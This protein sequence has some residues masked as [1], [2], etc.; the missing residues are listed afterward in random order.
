M[1][2]LVC[3]SLAVA[4]AWLVALLNRGQSARDFTW[5]Y[6]AAL[7]VRAGV[8][9]YLDLGSVIPAAWENARTTPLF[10]PLPA[11]LIAL[12]F[13]FLPVELAGVVFSMLSAFLLA[14]ALTEDGKYWRLWAFCSAPALVAFGNV[15]WSPL[16]L[17][18]VYLWWLGPIVIC[19]PSLGLA[20]WVARPRFGSLWIGSALVILSLLV[21]PSWPIDW[22][23]NLAKSEHVSP[24]LYAIPGLLALSFWASWHTSSG[25]FY[26][27]WSL[28]PQMAFFYDGLLLWLIPATKRQMWFLCACSWFAFFNMPGVGG[29][30]TFAARLVE[31]WLIYLP[32]L[33]LLLAQVYGGLHYEK[34]VIVG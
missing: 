16:L 6:A 14:W 27:V 17:A 15:Q 9:P 30:P 28:V 26:F 25:R 34:A 5:L 12:P 22:L 8:N 29:N 7:Q 13:S 19:K 11:V 4:V 31:Y 18:S 3:C 33:S 20:A 24:M 23:H 10:Y 2:L 21:L 32:A 1:R